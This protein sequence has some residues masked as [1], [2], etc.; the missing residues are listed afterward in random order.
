MFGFIE[1][2]LGLIVALLI[3]IL[4]RQEQYQMSTP[5]GLTALTAAVTALTTAVGNAVTELQTLAGQLSS[6]EDAQ[7]QAAA[8]Q[9]QTLATNLS[10]AVTA[11][12]TP[13]ASS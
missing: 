8:T 3:Y 7:V 1:F 13:P 5:P 11:A 6:N 2:E 10:A 4:I 9:I 12:Q